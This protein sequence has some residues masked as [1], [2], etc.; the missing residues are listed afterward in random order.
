MEIL[1]TITV[2]CLLIVL[3]LH[4]QLRFKV[5]NELAF[6]TRYIASVQ[7]NVP[8]DIVFDQVAGR[9]VAFARKDA[10]KG[11][12]EAKLLPDLTIDQ[13]LIGECESPRAGRQVV[14]KFLEKI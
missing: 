10:A 12:W 2:I 14:K 7:D 11:G 4:L 5:R 6:I 13:V 3:A 9:L 8:S 1:V